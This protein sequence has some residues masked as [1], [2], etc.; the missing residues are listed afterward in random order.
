MRR[1]AIALL[2]LCGCS[3]QPASHNEKLCEVFTDAAY[4]V[5]KVSGTGVDPAPSKKCCTECGKT[6][7][8]QS[9]DK[10]S[11]VSCPCD[12]SCECKSHG[13]GVCGGSGRRLSYDGNSIQRCGCK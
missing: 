4:A 5:V 6:G 12:K 1:T 9:G 7:Q 3:Q 10:L 13:C 11:W 8:V 2:L